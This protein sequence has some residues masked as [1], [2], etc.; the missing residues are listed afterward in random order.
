MR[1]GRGAGPEAT[2]GH[3]LVSIR[4]LLNESAE[5]RLEVTFR[6]GLINVQLFAR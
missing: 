6:H 5:A 1:R 3:E 4:L 2:F